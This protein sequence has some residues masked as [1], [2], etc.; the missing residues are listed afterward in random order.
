MQQ[1]AF[2]TSGQFPR[3][4][5]ARTMFLLGVLA[6]TEVLS[7]GQVLYGSLTGNITDPSNAVVPNAKI[8]ALNVGTGTSKTASTD[9][10]GVYLF[11]DLQSGN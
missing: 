6:L 11:N 7:H 1:R 5:L 3:Q 9:E 8:E 2:W 4:A 10:R